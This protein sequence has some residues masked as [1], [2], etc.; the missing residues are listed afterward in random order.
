MS[1]HASL[2]TAPGRRVS[3]RLALVT[4]LVSLWVPTAAHAAIRQVVPLQRPPGSPPPAGSNADLIVA[5]ITATPAST[6]FRS[7]AVMPR[8]AYMPSPAPT[9]KAAGR[10]Q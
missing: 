2:P 1:V 10:T 8:P 5:F 7:N 3:R 6:F 9:L 4:A